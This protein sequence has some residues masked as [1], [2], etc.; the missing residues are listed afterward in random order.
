LDINRIIVH[1]YVPLLCVSNATSSRETS[2]LSQG[3]TYSE[4]RSNN[5]KHY[6]I[7]PVHNPN[8]EYYECASLS[9]EV[10][11][12]LPFEGAAHEVETVTLDGKDDNLSR[13][14]FLSVHSD[15]ETLQHPLNSDRAQSVDEVAR[16][17]A[18]G[19]QELNSTPFA[20]VTQSMVLRKSALA[21]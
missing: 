21:A 16:E 4:T 12:S 1:R 19:G 14:S 17:S 5:F 9:L 13:A 6:D 20:L 10:S 7:Q 3:T 8:C 11:S 15:A 18:G 2:A